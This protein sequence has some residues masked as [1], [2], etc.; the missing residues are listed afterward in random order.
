MQ[1]RLGEVLP[2]LTDA[3]GRLVPDRRGSAPNDPSWVVD[4]FAARGLRAESRRATTVAG[5]YR[6]VLTL[7]HAPGVLV[8]LA[9]DVAERGLCHQARQ[10]RG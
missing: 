7:S 10:A 5:R 2:S 3:D 6:P 4:P 9:L 1:T 8:Q